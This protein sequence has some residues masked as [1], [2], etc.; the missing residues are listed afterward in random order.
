L[1]VSVKEP[2]STSDK[3]GAFGSVFNYSITGLPDSFIGEGTLP[4]QERR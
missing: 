4:A 3:R 2:T 1:K